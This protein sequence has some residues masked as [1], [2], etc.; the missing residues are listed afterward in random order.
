MRKSTKT[1]LFSVGLATAPIGGMA[2]SSDSAYA[3]WRC[4]IVKYGEPPNTCISVGPEGLANCYTDK[5]HTFCSVA[6]VCIL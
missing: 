2:V 3:C 5:A 6:G 1:F 4:S